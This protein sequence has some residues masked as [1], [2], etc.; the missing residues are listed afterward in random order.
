M[1]DGSTRVA[2]ILP[3][4]RPWLL[5][6]CPKARC[7]EAEGP[8]ERRMPVRMFPGAAVVQRTGGVLAV[9]CVLITNH[10]FPERCSM[11]CLWP[12]PH[13]PRTCDTSWC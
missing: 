5:T 9:L 4:T 7:V 11:S 12:R 6:V 10:V 3:L 2:M 1:R 13:Q 8:W